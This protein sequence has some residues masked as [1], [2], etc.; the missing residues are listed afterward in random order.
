[1]FSFFLSELL[2]MLSGK[3]ISLIARGNISLLQEAFSRSLSSTHSI[4][5]KMPHQPCMIHSPSG[6]CRQLVFGQGRPL[7][8]GS[9]NRFSFNVSIVK[10]LIICIPLDS[11]I[12][13]RI[14]LSR[15][16]VLP[17]LVF[18]S[19]KAFWVILLKSHD[20]QLIA[21]VTENLQKKASILRQW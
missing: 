10:E 9:V 17:L 3:L 13:L 8:C 6:V 16:T 5:L 19:R 12:S 21:Y 7:L 20:S 2:I 4:R 11:L 15:M 14:T 1:M 18:G